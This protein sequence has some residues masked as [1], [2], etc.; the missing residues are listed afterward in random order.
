M[1]NEEKREQFPYLNQ[2]YI[3]K[4]QESQL[5]NGEKVYTTEELSV[6][7]NFR[8]Y[9]TGTDENAYETNEPWFR[10]NYQV[11]NLDVSMLSNRIS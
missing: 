8:E 10:W 1:W 6:E 2:V 3:G 5:G 4:T 9:I 7:D 11:D